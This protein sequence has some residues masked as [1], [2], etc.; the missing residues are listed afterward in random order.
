MFAVLLGAGIENLYELCYEAEVEQDL[1]QVIRNVNVI[2]A[3]PAGMVEIAG[4]YDENTEKSSQ[5]SSKRLF[6]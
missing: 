1:N 6:Q 2:S 4:S 5:N 3:F